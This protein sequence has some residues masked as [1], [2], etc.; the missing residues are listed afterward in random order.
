VVAAAAAVATWLRRDTF[1]G[2]A[3]SAA[4]WASS[5]RGMGSVGSTAATTWGGDDARLTLGAAGM[6]GSALPPLA[7]AAPPTAAHGRQAD[8]HLPAKG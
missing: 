1:A 6:R 8:N 5:A 7:S 2:R 4:T 3:E